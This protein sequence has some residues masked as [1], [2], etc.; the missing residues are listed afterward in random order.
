MGMELG[1]KLG[2][3]LEP[4]PALN[5][6]HKRYNNSD[7]QAQPLT[8]TLPILSSGRK[9]VCQCS[10][11]TSHIK[12]ITE[13]IAHHISVVGCLFIFDGPQPEASNPRVPASRLLSLFGHN[14]TK[15]SSFNKTGTQAHAAPPPPPPPSPPYYGTPRESKSSPSPTSNPF[16]PDHTARS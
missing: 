9:S 16:C 11:T 1:L 8:Y 13:S 6:R 10:V 7:S 2:M 15:L 3:E 5:L 14:S 12:D 4:T